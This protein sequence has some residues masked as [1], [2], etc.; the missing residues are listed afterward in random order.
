MPAPTTTLNI[1][2]VRPFMQEVQTILSEAQDI[3][4]KVAEE[5]DQ[6]VGFQAVLKTKL[7][8]LL[9]DTSASGPLA[10][11]TMHARVKDMLTACFLP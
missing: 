9:D 8:E 3:V 5:N 7:Q 4:I 10:N 11:E 2:D 6:L 1:H